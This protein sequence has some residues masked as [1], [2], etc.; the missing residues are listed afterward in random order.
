[1]ARKDA[2]LAEIGKALREYTKDCREDMH[3]PDEQG[4]TAQFFGS[5]FD[6]ACGNA[7]NERAILHDYQ[8]MVV[9]LRQDRNLNPLV[10]NLAD[11]IALARKADV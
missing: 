1:M 9:I 11:L 8:E 4:F 7:I 10:I 6:N 5:K 2:R 3:E